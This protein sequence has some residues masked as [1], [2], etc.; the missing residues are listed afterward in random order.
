MIILKK[1]LFQHALYAIYRK[2]YIKTFWLFPHLLLPIKNPHIIGLELTNNCN[3]ECIHCF[4]K[5]MN[6]DLGYMDVDLFKKLVDEIC[7]YPVAF[8]RI[9]G[10]GEPALHPEL[11][12]IMEYLKGKQIKIEFCTNGVLFEKFSFTEILSWN[13]DLLDISVDGIDKEPYN[14]IR[15]KGDYD[16]LK[17]NISNFIIIERFQKK[18][19]QKLISGM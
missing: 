18:V 8:L 17:S 10:R 15:K 19:S 11:E 1:K 14:K 16:K 7:T 5:K 2:V 9:V 4:R 12:Q 13:I 3:L 6:K